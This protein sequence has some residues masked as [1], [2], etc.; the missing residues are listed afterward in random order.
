M[1]GHDPD[2]THEDA[3]VEADEADDW[4]DT[5][6]HQGVEY[7]LQWTHHHHYHYHH[8]ITISTINL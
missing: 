6:G 1:I 2:G 5:R 8:H 4:D 3:V 7:L